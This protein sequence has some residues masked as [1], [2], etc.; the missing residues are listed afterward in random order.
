MLL[1]YSNADSRA[2]IEEHADAVMGQVDDLMAELRASGELIGGQAL[3]DSA[4]TVRVRGGVPAVTDGPFVEAKELMAGYLLVE[5]DG[6]ERATEIAAR[7]PDAELC[8]MEI[9]PVIDEVA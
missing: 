1:I 7:W 8:A 6:I 3:A 4:R 2:Y 9:R 5:C